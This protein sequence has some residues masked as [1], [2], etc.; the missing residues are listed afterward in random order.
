MSQQ[1]KVERDLVFAGAANYTDN[2]EGNPSTTKVVYYNDFLTAGA[3]ETNDVAINESHG[4]SGAISAAVGG[5]YRLTTSTTDNDKAELALE[6]CWEAAKACVME[7]R[8]KVDAITTVGMVV[9]FSDAKSEADNQVAFEI[10][11]ATIVD[12]CTDGVAFCFDTD[13]SNVYWYCCQTKAGTQTGTDTSI[14]PV[15]ATYEVLRV[16]LDT[17][18]N[19]VFYRNGVK[20][21]NIASAVTTTTDMTPYIAVISRAGTAA[22]N[23]DVDYIKAWQNRT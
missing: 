2:I 16:E 3:D 1:V 19:A 5:T 14:A 12:R 15:A 18:G 11:G 21:A 9:G 22:R 20:V 10:S 23:M 6:L 7:A 17:S 8:V 4:G 13:A